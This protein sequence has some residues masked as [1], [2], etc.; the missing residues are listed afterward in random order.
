MVSLPMKAYAFGLDFDIGKYKYF[1]WPIL[2]LLVLVAIFGR[3]IEK[4][5]I[6]KYGRLKTSVILIVGLIVFLG[7]VRLMAQY[8]NWST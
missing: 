5:L 3:K 7:L 8:G 2:I 1:V 6:E 4:E